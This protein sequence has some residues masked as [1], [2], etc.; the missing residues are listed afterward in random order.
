MTKVVPYTK[1]SAAYLRTYH[2]QTLQRFLLIPLFLFPLVSRAEDR[3]LWLNAATAG[4][5]LDGM[6]DVKVTK[7]PMAGSPQVQT[8][9]AT[10]S[11]GPMSANPTGN[12][13][14]DVGVDDA[15]CV[16]KRQPP[17]NGQLRIQVRT[18]SEPAKAFLS[19][20]RKC[21]THGT[22]LKAIGNEAILC[23]AKAKGMPEQVVG[24]VRDRLFV[25]SLNGT[26]PSTTA[27]ALRE[28]VQTAAQI[29]AGNLF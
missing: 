14:A 20:A 22:P 16:F 5:I 12:S 18:M 26:D 28:K 24:R 17:A 8:A 6:V 1:V 11:A 10:S 4:G 2:M 9:N 21:G 13:Y 15:E 19:Y 25:I 29:V 23:E 3:C 27:N 7:L